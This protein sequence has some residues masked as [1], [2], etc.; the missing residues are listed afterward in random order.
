MTALTMPPTDG[1]R[2]VT[3]APSVRDIVLTHGRYVW[4][5]LRYFGVADRDLDDVSQDVFTT[6][7]R[8]LDDLS[9]DGLRPW[10]HTICVNHVKNYR[11]RARHR[12]ETL[13]DNVP[14]AVV[15]APQ[16][17][18][19]ELAQ[20][21]R[22]LLVLLDRLDEDRRTVFVLHAIEEVPMEQVAKIVGCPLSTAYFRF[23]RARV[24]LEK[25]LVNP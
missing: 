11:R 12:R 20:A 23:Q 16:E 17:E 24:E 21:Q 6:V 19:L 14:E 7:H 3:Q 9:D 10:L 4:R 15:S 18:T 5:L 13:V 2:L 8:K 25:E 1:T 22:L